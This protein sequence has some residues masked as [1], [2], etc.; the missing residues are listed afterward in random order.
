MEINVEILKTDVLEQLPQFQITAFRIQ[1]QVVGIKH[2]GTWEKN[3]TTGRLK[4][5]IIVHILNAFLKNHTQAA[6]IR[7]KMHH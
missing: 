5:S 3:F 6:L 4:Q 7:K 2:I 1:L